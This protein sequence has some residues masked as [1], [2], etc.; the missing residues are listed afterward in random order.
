MKFTFKTA[1]LILVYALCWLP[2]TAFAEDPSFEVTVNTKKVALGSALQLTLTFEGG[3]TDPPQ[4]PTVDGLDIKYMGPSTSISIINGQYSSSVSHLYT[5]F[6]LKVGQFRI[7]ALAV[8][9]G[10]KDLISEPIDIEVVDAQSD[11][12]GQ[13]NQTASIAQSIKDKIFLT[14]ETTKKEAFVDERIG[15]TIKL[16]INGLAVKEI[17]YPQ[18]E[19]NG[20]IVEEYGQPKQYQQVIGGARYSVV[21]F[22]THIAS[23]KPGALTLGPVKLDCNLLFENSQHRRL[24]TTGFDGF[25]D[26]SIFDNFFSHYEKRPVTISSADIPIQVLPLPEGG[27]PENFSGAVGQFALEA[28]ATPQEVVVGDPVTLRM[29]ILGTGSLQSITMPALKLGEDFKLYDPQIKEEG[30]AKILEQVAIPKSEKI[31]EIPAVTFSYFDPERK[32]YE[33]LTQGPFPLKVN[34]SEAKD[35]FKVVGFGEQS[36]SSSPAQTQVEESF[37]RDIVFIKDQPGQLQLKGRYLFQNPFFIV[38]VFVLLGVWGLL[39]AVYQRKQ[40]IESDVVYARRLYAPQKAKQGLETAQKFMMEG[41]Q[42][43][44]YDQVF[45]T[46]REYLAGKLHLNSAHFTIGDIEERIK[47]QA[48]KKN[49]PKDSDFTLTQVRTVLDQCEGV[50]YALANL[51]QEQMKENFEQMEKVIDYFERNWK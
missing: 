35:D 21:E 2:F 7:P 18:F 27:R 46:L 47:N 24:P 37:G 30:G 25:F 42:K 1:V 40:K 34:K 19:H 43:E 12:H 31:T 51:T 11:A 48:K 41:K 32:S 9:M 45:K 8:N 17:Q 36:S 29:K 26:D 16:F 20:F 15:L 6:P 44:F 5:V 23:T 13:D 22:N 4:I 38:M 33:T 3:K 39:I 28:S 14:L 10:G 49:N 50:R